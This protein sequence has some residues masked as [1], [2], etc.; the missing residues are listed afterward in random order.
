MV[1]VMAAGPLVGGSN[2]W[3]WAGAFVIA[4]VAVVLFLKSYVIKDD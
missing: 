2:P 1:L 3:T 4:V